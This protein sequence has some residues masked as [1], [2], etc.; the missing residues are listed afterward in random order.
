MKLKLTSDAS[1]RTWEVKLINGQ[2]FSH[3]WEDF[4]N[5]HCLR[6]DHV[7]VFRHDGDML[8]HVTPTGRSFSQKKQQCVSSSEEDD[9]DDDEGMKQS[10]FLTVTL[11]PYMLTYKQIRV[12]RR[13]AIENGMKEAGKITLVDKHGDQGFYISKGWIGFCAAN[14]L[15]A[16]DTFKFEFVGGEGKTPMLKFCWTVQASRDKDKDGQEDNETRVLKRA[17]VSTEEGSSRCTQASNKSR[18]EPENLQRKPPLQSCSVS[19]QLAKVKQSIV[20]TLTGIR[21]FRSE[22]EIK[23]QNLEASLKELDVLGEKVL[24]INKILK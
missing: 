8:F 5:A 15:K 12:R 3:G 14:E 4:S 6:D 13:F 23:E 10:R 18:A 16:G 22:L 9:N 11:K 24:E 1:D 20:Y 21:Q 19:E 2:R 7:L 17:R